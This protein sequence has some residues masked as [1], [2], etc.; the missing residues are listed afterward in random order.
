MRTSAPVTNADIWWPTAVAQGT[1]FDYHWFV[2][3]LAGCASALHTSLDDYDPDTV[4]GARIKLI[5]LC[6]SLAPDVPVFVVPPELPPSALKLAHALYAQLS[7][8]QF[9]GDDHLESQLN[10]AGGEG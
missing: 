7:E 2:E 3:Y 5:E 6:P 9:L 8:L 10:E 1:E 4:M